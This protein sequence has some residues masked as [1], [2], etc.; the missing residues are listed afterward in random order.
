[1]LS[2]DVTFLMGKCEGTMFI[3]IG[4]DADRQLVSLAFAIVEKEN[5]STWGWFLCLVR[6]VVV[7]TGCEIF[8]IFDRYAGTLNVIGAHDT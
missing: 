8:V 4:I 6:R 2:I 3:A 1:V 5:N 7:G